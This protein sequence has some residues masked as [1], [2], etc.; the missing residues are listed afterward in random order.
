MTGRLSRAGLLRRGAAG[1]GA[2]LLS[3][4]A[5]SVFAT[6]AGAATIPDSDLTYLRLLVGAEL[7]AADFQAQAIASGKLT[8]ALAAAT[9][10]MLADEKAHYNSL[11]TLITGAGQAPATS[12]DINFTYPKRSFGSEASMLKLGELDRNADVGRVSGSGREHPDTAAAVADRADR[13]ERGS[14]CERGGGRGWEA[15]HRSRICPRASDR[16][17]VSRPRRVRELIMPR[18]L[19]AASE[20]A[21]ALGISLDTLRRW[22]KSGRIKVERDA[23]NRRVVPASEIER[24]RG[25]GAGAHLSARNRFNAVVTDVKV[26]GLIA[27]VEMVVTEPVRLVAVVTRDA[28]E[29]LGLKNGMSAT[30]IVKSTSVMVQI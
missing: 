4:S 18:Q 5:V 11:S 13:R 22:D 2:L 10:Q 24:L 1:S 23:A 14:A 27:Q 8:P 19:Y 28:I 20:A 16:R 30:A 15:D 17:C 6:A 12:D 26:D 9:K 7:L 21:A 25:D 29:E 3:G